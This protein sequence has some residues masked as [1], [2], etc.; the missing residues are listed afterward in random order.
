MDPNRPRG[1]VQGVMAVGLIA[2]GL[3]IVIPLLHLLR[4]GL[5]SPVVSR[6][7]SE[8]FGRA[9]ISLLALG[10]VGWLLGLVTG[11]KRTAGPR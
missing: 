4:V 2:A 6:Y 8:A 3:W 5:G 7:I 10:A 1:I 9:I 11:Q